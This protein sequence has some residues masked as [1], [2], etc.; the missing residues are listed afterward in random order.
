MANRAYAKLVEF[1]NQRVGMSVHQRLSEYVMLYGTF[2][3][4]YY[5]AKLSHEVYRSK[6]SRGHIGRRNIRENLKR[7]AYRRLP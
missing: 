7:Y 2:H 5:L 3:L 4:N 1:D 6:G